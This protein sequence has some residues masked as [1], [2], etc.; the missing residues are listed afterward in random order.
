LCLL[1]LFPPCHDAGRD[2]SRV[3]A[4]LHR[5][6]CRFLVR[7]EHWLEEAKRYLRD[8]K[9]KWDDGTDLK[10]NIASF[11][12]E[13]ESWGMTSYILNRVTALLDAAFPP[14]A[15]AKD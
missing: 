3:A 15:E 12:S 9:T 4:E 5:L 13:Y 7:N 8:G 1:N 6:T 2:V 10:D 11:Q 14:P